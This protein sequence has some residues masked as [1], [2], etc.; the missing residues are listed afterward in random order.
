MP[1]TRDD[2]R[3]RRLPAALCAGAISVAAALSAAGL[4]TLFPGTGAAQAPPAADYFNVTADRSSLRSINGETVLELIRNV[5]V[6][7][8][9]VTLNA[10]HGLSY[11]VL[12]LTTL[13]GNVRV[14]QREMTMTGAEG[15][16]RQ[17]EDLAILRRNVRIVDPGWVITCDEARFSRRTGQAWL[18]GNVVA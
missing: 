15:E 3:P 4:S 1:T 17:N 2:H 5:V 13:D 12:R 6:I 16:Y 18:I 7:H 10:D 14:V 9:D 11:T 8:G